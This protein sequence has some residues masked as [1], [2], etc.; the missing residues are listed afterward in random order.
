LAAGAGAQ[1]RRRRGEHSAVRH[2][3]CLDGKVTT[4]G[5]GDDAAAPPYRQEPAM[6]HT[7]EFDAE[8]TIDLEIS[9]KHPLERLCIRQGT[10]R[11]A[12]IRPYVVETPDVPV[13]VAALFFED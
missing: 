1:P 13:E 9:R 2:G 8:L 6:Y 10:R 11:R 5:A 12:Q 4:A 7:L 3:N